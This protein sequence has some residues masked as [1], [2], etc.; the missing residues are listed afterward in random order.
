MVNRYKYILILL[1]FGL[2]AGLS[3]QEPGAGNFL[4]DM[5]IVIDDS[6]AATQAGEGKTAPTETTD[7]EQ[8]RLEEEL[9]RYQEKL[10]LTELQMMIQTRVIDS[11]K[12]E[13][14][15][16]NSAR[17]TDMALLNSKIS[18]LEEQQTVQESSLPV[19]PSEV[20]A[21][22]DS[23]WAELTTTEGKARYYQ[24]PQRNQDL[25]V[26]DVNAE[27]QLYRQALTKFHQQYHYSAIEDFKTI[28]G[29]GTNSEIRA[30]AQY[31]IG[32]SYYEKGLYDEAIVSLEKVKKFPGSDKQ[33]DALAMIGLAFQHK[34][35]LAE[36][37]VA[38]KE[39]VDQHPGSE[40][41]TLARRFIRN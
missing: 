4:Y 2:I 13:I 33:D 22:E 35:N 36:A 37:K 28:V 24:P 8:E 19:E 5:G 30:N 9:T 20:N 39:L 32:R 31:W 12:S 15:R 41:L 18:S 25:P 23:A 17:K 7:Q 21:A 14:I 6:T 3:A 26:L 34:N 10:A 16:V 1:G 29:R 40:Y 27:R 38:F 11:L